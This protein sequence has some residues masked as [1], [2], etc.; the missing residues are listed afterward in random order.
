M[1][2]RITEFLFAGVLDNTVLGEVKGWI[3]LLGIEGKVDIDLKGDFHRDI[4]GVKI[5]FA[6]NLW[7]DEKFALDY[8]RYFKKRQTGKVGDITAGLPPRDF[9]PFPYIEWYGNENG[10]VV[11][12]LDP[13]QV[14]VIGVPIP[15]CES[16]P[17]SRDEQD[18][19]MVDYLN[20]I[21]ETTGIKDIRVIGIEMLPEDGELQ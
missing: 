19:N 7:A 6:N 17:I 12:E 21:S 8:L 16:E 10:R 3:K 1:A 4:R 11:I 2:C 18:Q 13:D 14:E 15:A 5:R 9:T 20:R